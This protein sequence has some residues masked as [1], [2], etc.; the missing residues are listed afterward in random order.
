VY[1][2]PVSDGGMVKVTTRLIENK[3]ASLTAGQE[4]HLVLITQYM[5]G[6]RELNAPRTY[7]SPHHPH[8]VHGLGGRRLSHKYGT[9]Q[10]PAGRFP[11]STAEVPAPL[12]RKDPP[13]T[14][15]TAC[16]FPIQ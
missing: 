16:Q 1:F 3:P 15:E 6:R 12:L 8:G 9:Y 11:S 5:Y 4:L 7:E 10:S 14:G 2:R 13:P